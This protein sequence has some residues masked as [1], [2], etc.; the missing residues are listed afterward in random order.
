MGIL[1]AINPAEFFYS[2][3]TVFITVILITTVKVWGGISINGTAIGTDLNLA[4]YGFIWD[5]CTKALRGQD[6]WPRF[7][8][9]LTFLNKPVILLLIFVGNFLIM[10]LNLKLEDIV[11]QR[12]NI[13]VQPEQNI[14]VQPKW[15]TQML[16]KPLVIAL[17]VFSLI[18]FLLLNSAWS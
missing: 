5:I 7:S 2:F 1:S 4:T 15:V 18:I 16:L 13:S 3:L 9:S 17:G 6:F 10:A 8:V 11:N 12:Q 14:R